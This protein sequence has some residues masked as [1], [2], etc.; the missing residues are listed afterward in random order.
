MEKNCPN[1]GYK[2]ITI[3]NVISCTMCGYKVGPKILT[4][5]ERVNQLETEISDLRGG[6]YSIIILCTLPFIIVLFAYLFLLPFLT[7]LDPSREF[8]VFVKNREITAVSIQNLYRRNEWIESMEDSERIELVRRI[9]EFFDTNIKHRLDLIDY[10][11]DLALLTD[12]TFYFI[13][14]NPFGTKY[15]AGS[16]LFGWVQDHDI[17]HDSSSIEFRYP[18]DNRS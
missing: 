8:R 14:P 13:E 15:S 11:F 1:C 17:L 7:N 2:L 6:S 10:T 16:S 4:L 18:V 9:V 12:D 5:E 3:E